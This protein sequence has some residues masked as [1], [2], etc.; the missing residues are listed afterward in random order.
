MFRK[1][2]MTSFSVLLIFLFMNNI[3]TTTVLGQSNNNEPT[4]EEIFRALNQ[5]EGR[6]LDPEKDPDIDMYIG[7]WRDSIP[8]NSHGSLVERA[9]LT[10]TDGDPLKPTKKG[11]VL[12]VVNRL[13]RAT[14]DP[15]AITTPT[16]LRGEQEIFYVMSGKGFVKAGGKSYELR[17]GAMFL[18]PEGLEFTMTNTSDELMEM[19]LI[20]EPV[21]PGYEPNTEI[22]INYEGEMPLRN[23][24]YIQVHWSHNG[25]GGIQGATLGTGRLIINAMTIAQPHSHNMS[26]E[27]VWLCTEGKNLEILGKEI[28]WTTPGMAFRVPPTGF[29]PHGHIN[30]TEK[31]VR[32][33]IW[34]ARPAR[35]T[36]NK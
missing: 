1:I 17:K 33:M 11:E 27:E 31:P 23:E 24:G 34:I 28:R 35:L 2:F 14:L 21:P 10:K 30:T 9:I 16:T 15:K 25:R 18:A 7:N 4:K 20:N 22:D 26:S 29:T 32:F 12:S 5:L 6:P 36:P 3:S 13:T 8:F 19:Y